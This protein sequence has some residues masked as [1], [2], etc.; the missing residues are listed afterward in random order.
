MRAAWRLSRERGGEDGSSRQGQA[1]DRAAGGE[2][3]G[4]WESGQMTP[5]DGGIVKLSAAFTT[6]DTPLMQPV[7]TPVQR[8]GRRCRLT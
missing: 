3:C 5:S 1:A 7:K 4:C 8:L 2:A 6:S